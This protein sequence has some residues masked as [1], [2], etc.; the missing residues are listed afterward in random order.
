MQIYASTR[1]IFLSSLVWRKQ[2]LTE[3]LHRHRASLASKLLRETLQG[4]LVCSAGHFPPG[5]CHV[6]P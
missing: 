6:A 2:I 4:L 1:V 3:C 5:L